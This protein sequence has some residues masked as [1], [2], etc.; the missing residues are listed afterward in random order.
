MSLKYV[1]LNAPSLITPIGILFAPKCIYET[2]LSSNTELFR[3]LT[4]SFL[5]IH[6]KMNL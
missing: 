3:I 5:L 1:P 4:A 2:T 6:N